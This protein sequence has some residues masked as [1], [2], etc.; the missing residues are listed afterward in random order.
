MRYNIG[1]AYI[2]SAPNDMLSSACICTAKRVKII[3]SNTRVRTVLYVH[4]P[5]Y[6]IMCI[7]CGQR[8]LRAA[9]LNEKYIMRE[10]REKLILVPTIVKIRVYWA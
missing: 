7:R 9:Q 5:K 1:R 4:T 8:D 2:N 10:P 3:D 6:N